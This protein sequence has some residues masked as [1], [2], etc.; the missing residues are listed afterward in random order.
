MNLILRTL[1][2]PGQHMWM[3][4]P[5]YPFIR[6]VVEAGQLVVDAIPVDDEGMDIAWGQRH[7]PQARFALLTPAHQIRWAWRCR[8]PG[9]ASCWHG[10]RSV[11]HGS[12]RTI[13]I[14]SFAIAANRC[15]R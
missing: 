10:P 5:G 11:T 12:L 1:A 14:A 7:H 8:C 13:T 2:Q 15:R 3:E 6:P 9:V 4:D